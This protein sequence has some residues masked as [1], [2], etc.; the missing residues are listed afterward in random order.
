ARVDVAVLDVDLQL[1]DLRAALLEP[2]DDPP[3][4]GRALV[5]D[6]ER[7]HPA[8]TASSSRSTCAAISRTD[9]A[10]RRTIS[11]RSSSLVVNGGAKRLWSPAIPSR[12]GCVERM[13]RP[14]SSATSSR[15]AATR[16]SGGRNDSPSRGSTYST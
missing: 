8:G 15:R 10:K 16:S 9:S 5:L 11:A 13:T 1:L 14:R 2:V 4:G 12:V 3:A 7:L 6:D